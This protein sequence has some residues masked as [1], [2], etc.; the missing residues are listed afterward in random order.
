MK[1]LFFKQVLILTIL[2]SLSSISYTQ[3]CNLGGTKTISLACGTDCTNLTFKV[4]NFKSTEEYALSNIP[5]TPALPYVTATGVEL[6][7][8]YDD[9]EY[10]PALNLPFKFCMY[11]SSFNQFIVG[12][13]GILSFDMSLAG[14]KNA[15]TVNT[16]IPFEGT[17][18][19][20]NQSGPRYPKFA[21]F[22]PYHDLDPEV[23]SGGAA[24]RKIEY[25]IEGTAPCRKLI[26]SFYN[27]AMFSCNS[28]IATSQIVAYE[29]SNLIDVYI[30][31]KPVCSSWQNGRSVLGI[32]KDDTK[33]LPVP[34]H[35]A[36]DPVWSESNTAYRFKPNGATNT[37]QS[38][39][40]KKKNGTIVGNGTI[41]T[42]VGDSL[43]INY[44]NFCLP[45]GVVSDTLVI[46]AN[47]NSCTGIAVDNFTLKDTIYV[48]RINGGLLPTAVTTAASCTGVNNGAVTINVS[49]GTGAYQ[50]ALNG[51]T[52]QNGN[53]FNNLQT[54]SHTVTVKDAANC[55]GNVT[56][57]ITA[58]AGITASNVVAATSCNGATD[59]SVTLTGS[60]GT[61]PYQY[62]IGSN[63]F[64]STNVFNNLNAGN[65]SFTVRDN[66]GCIATTTA[67]IAPG[68]NL[69][70][71]SS[72]VNVT[73]NGLNNG[74][75]TLTATNGNGGYQF[76]LNNGTPQ[77]SNI[78]N[79]LI[80]GTYNLNVTSANGCNGSATATITQPAL[81]TATTNVTPV[82]CNGETNGTIT[83]SAQGGTTP[84]S[85]S[86]NNGTSFQNS[87]IFN[88]A[89]GT[90]AIV[91]KDA[92][93]CL[94]NMNATVTQPNAIAATTT[95]TNASC[96]GGADGSITINASGGTLPF[97]YA[98]NG[99]AFQNS[100]I[101]VVIAGN[102]TII[103]KDANNC[104]Y[105]INAT[106]G[107]TSDL[108]VDVRT[109]TTICEGQS[110]KLVTNTNALIYNWS[111]ITSLNN[112]NIK[113]PIASPTTTTK[114]I[115][116]ATLGACTAKDSIT[117]T[118]N[119]API[120]NAGADAEI[121]FGLT[122]TLQGSGGV[123]YTWTPSTALNNTNIQNPISSSGNSIKY[124]VHVVDAN[125][126]H[127]LQDDEMQLTVT[128]PLKAFA[129]VDSTI[130]TNQP[131]QLFGTL[132]PQPTNTT[133]SYNWMPSFGLNNPLIQNPIATLNITQTYVL[134]ITTAAGCKG[135]DTVKLEVLKGPD[136][137]VP[138][139]FT[140]NNDGNNDLFKVYTV[141]I[142]K[143]EFLR[144]F[145]RWGQL[146]FETKDAKKGWNATQRGKEVPSGAY[147][148]HVRGI[149][150]KG[151]VIDKKGSVVI[152][153]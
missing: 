146:V 19:C 56:F 139:I 38:V 122:Y 30:L 140:P 36:N 112:P 29:S 8:L 12:S 87:N 45:T 48:T 113:E 44:N 6:T 31:N 82:L 90:Y 65:H 42:V 132:V 59:G 100:N 143:I 93:N 94:V 13:N 88:V 9:D 133:L 5:F 49:G 21:T 137:Y 66:N 43:N 74:N 138:T 61:S 20:T 101:F 117:V 110:V 92:N 129:G 105:N 121:C 85:Y 75:I 111:S 52:F 33:A 46:E 54:G 120:A 118:V 107:L 10:T 81:L 145:N 4:P 39:I 50:F 34:N 134:E 11:N 40:I 84:Y 123:Q 152:A 98:L 104:T 28:Q 72:I 151:N 25:R 70:L 51:G 99:G 76:T 77:S 58:G 53:T 124:A 35:N 130:V 16:N 114:Y 128:P 26:V 119:A 47:Y 108:F 2:L 96:N 142:E 97:T 60:A 153:R 150:D 64:V 32:Q 148:F 1:I 63:G 83:V 68:P 79:N 95:I 22:S 135:L 24:S 141:G 136:I 37:L 23:T 125:N 55:A 69:N 106:V 41:G 62:Q 18:S 57:T 103:V 102:H 27:I 91:V 71:T 15:W 78:F 131:Y 127:S 86:N 17:G 115:L 73:C 149:T 144:V 89:A 147:I 67:V 3:S 109:D 126:C 7:D 116:T 14:C 80:A